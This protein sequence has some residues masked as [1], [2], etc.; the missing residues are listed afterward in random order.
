MFPITKQSIDSLAK[1]NGAR[2]Y[3][4]QC[5]AV[6]QVVFENFGPDE[7]APTV[8]TVRP[9]SCTV[10]LNGY[11]EA[12][13]FELEFDAHTFPFSPDLVR[14]IGVQL[15]LFQT[16]G[17]QGELEHFNE[18]NENL[19]VSGLADDARYHAGPDGRTFNICGR[20]YTSLMLDKPWPA[21]RRIPVGKS[22]AAVVQDLVDECALP[23]VPEL[24]RE[25]RRHLTVRTIGDAGSE[26]DTPTLG[27]VNATEGALITAGKYSVSKKGKLTIPKAGASHTRCNKKGIPVF[28]GS[29][30]WDVIYRMC[31]RHGFIVFV[32]GN[33]VVISTPATLTEASLG[34]V[35]S[36]A[37]GRD[38]SELEI[39]RKLGHETV[40]Q[41]K[42]VCYD[43]TRRDAIEATWPKDP[44]KR[45]TGIGTQREEVRLV[46]VYGITD[47]GA[48]LDVAKLYYQNLS[49]S[50]AS[51]RFRTIDLMDMDGNDLLFLRPGDPV[52]IGF[53]AIND[54][55]FRQIT[56]SE[57]LDRLLSLGYDEQ[58]AYLIATEYDKINQ[59]REPF[60]TS[61][62]TFNWDVSTG[63]AIEVKAINYISVGRDD[64]R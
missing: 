9:R 55:E 7:K 56:E 53:D 1:Q 61:D 38:L 44:P 47:Q 22:L 34:R 37:Y 2:V 33:D 4:P 43:S 16:S 28:G 21:D 5:Y 41:I 35:R 3:Y 63:L 62:V 17:I 13:S 54:E 29:N 46:T 8:I 50:E 40:P 31:V 19:I 12:D 10:H 15:H 57:R 59:F 42:C 26:F 27:P 49:R 30:Y 48:L 52:Q 45:I 20:D 24:E 36:M 18:D 11:R 6:L 25:A 51:V 60:Y 39:D 32:R 23:G 64:V 58:V 14:A